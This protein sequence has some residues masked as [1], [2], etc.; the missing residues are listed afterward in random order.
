MDL[1]N[2][3]AIVLGASTPGGMGE[4]MARRVGGKNATPVS[5]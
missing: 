5:A 1:E 3:V 4:V 2:K